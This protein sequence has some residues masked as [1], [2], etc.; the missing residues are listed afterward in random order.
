MD[1]ETGPAQ[2]GALNELLTALWRRLEIA[3]DL[4]VAAAPDLDRVA[5]LCR[6]AAGLAE[7]GAI[8]GRE[9]LPARTDRG[10]EMRKALR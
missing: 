7:A 2:P 3:L 10:A 4:S 1:E 9:P 8:L 5:A 6:E